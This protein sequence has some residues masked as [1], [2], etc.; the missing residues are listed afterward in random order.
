MKVYNVW[1][2][3]EEIDENKDNGEDI[4]SRKLAK[5]DNEDDA[6]SFIE[7]IERANDTPR[8]KNGFTLK[9]DC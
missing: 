8:D 1:V 4:E 2:C 6:V 3:V 7:D 9:E 5:F